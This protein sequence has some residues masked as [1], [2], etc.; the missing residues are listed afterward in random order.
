MFYY[1]CYIVSIILHKKHF[2]ELLAVLLATFFS[3]FCM[4]A[5][6]KS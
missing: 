2:A 1:N 6:L 5:H 3:S 4:F